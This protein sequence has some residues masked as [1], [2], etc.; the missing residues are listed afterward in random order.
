[1]K[2]TKRKTITALI[3]GIVL[4]VTLIANGSAIQDEVN[5]LKDVSKWDVTMLISCT[6][7]DK[8]T[9]RY[10]CHQALFLFHP[11]AEEVKRLNREA[12]AYYAALLKD[13]NE[14]R[15]LLKRFLDKG[16]DINSADMRGL[17]PR[18]TAL[19]RSVLPYPDLQ[20]MR[21]LLEAGADPFIKDAKG[22]TPLDLAKKFQT[23]KPHY[24]YRAGIELLEQTMK[25]R[26]PKKE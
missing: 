7:V 8:G 4:I 15:R 6:D 14:A 24:N 22:D 25:E 21:L 17:T 1:M 11:T 12:G 23:L 20:A 9:L 18:W 2:M 16:V 10:Y 3:V 19:H 13:E 26:A 5:K